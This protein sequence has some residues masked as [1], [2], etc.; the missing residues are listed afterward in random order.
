MIP[1]NMP[2]A[3]SKYVVIK[4]YMDANHAGNTEIGGHILASS[5]M[6]IIYLSSGTLNNRTHLMLQVLYQSFLLLG[7]PQR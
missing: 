5:Y 2:D 4:A 3:L 6:S 7:L 1:R